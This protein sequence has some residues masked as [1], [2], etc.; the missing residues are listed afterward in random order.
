MLF[1]SREIFLFLLVIGALN[2]CTFLLKEEKRPEGEEIYLQEKIKEKWFPYEIKE[3]GGKHI[4]EIFL[5]K[6]RIYFAK[7][8]ASVGVDK[9]RIQKSYFSL[10]KNE[11]IVSCFLPLKGEYFLFPIEKIYLEDFGGKII[12]IDLSAKRYWAITKIPKTQFLGL[13]GFVKTEIWKSKR[14]K[15]IK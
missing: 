8:K 10:R 1:K 6:M 7:E 13:K 11:K 4:L 12:F 5:P 15:R 14:I 9:K 2:L 3:E